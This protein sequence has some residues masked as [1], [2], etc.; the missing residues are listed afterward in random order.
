MTTVT[1]APTAAELAALLRDTAERLKA[2]LQD[3]GLPL[4]DLVGVLPDLG[5]T[6]QYLAGGVRAVV[7]AIREEVDLCCSPDW[8]EATDMLDDAA[9]RFGDGGLTLEHAVTLTGQG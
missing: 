3:P 5:D 4:G 6:G 7:D 2:A 1:P 9:S 8:Q